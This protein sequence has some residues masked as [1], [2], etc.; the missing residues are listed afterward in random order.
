MRHTRLRLGSEKEVS[1]PGSGHV[2]TEPTRAITQWISLAVVIGVHSLASLFPA[3]EEVAIE[4]AKSD[5]TL[6]ET[7]KSG[8]CNDVSLVAG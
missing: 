3:R 5:F 6:G 7:R 4:V 2:S 1:L 8:R